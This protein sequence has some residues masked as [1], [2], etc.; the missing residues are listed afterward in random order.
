MGDERRTSA[1]LVAFDLVDEGILVVAVDRDA[2]FP[3]VDANEAALRMVDREREDVVG[4]PLAELQ[5]AR[6]VTGFARR[7]DEALHTGLAQRAQ[8]IDE[9]PAGRVTLD[10]SLAPIPDPDD[11]PAHVVVVLR[12]VTALLRITDT[13]YEVEEVTSTGTWSWDVDGDTVRWSSRLYDLFGL[14]RDEMTPSFAELPRARPPR[15]PGRPRGRDRRHLRGGRAV[16]AAPPRRHA[17][18][19]DPPA[20]LHR[21]AGRPARRDPGPDDGHGAARARRRRDHA[22]LSATGA[23]AQ[24]ALTGRRQ[25]RPGNRAKSRSAEYQ[26]APC[27]MHIAAR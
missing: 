18:G 7:V 13:L 8:V 5:S 22:L 21:P 26:V 17:C 16:R 6:V 24:L 23:L 25:S 9:G 3:V 27:S 12:D 2:G 19:R 15:R 1:A 20:A 4:R 14:R 10:V 11:A